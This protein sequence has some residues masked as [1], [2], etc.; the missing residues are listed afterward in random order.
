MDDIPL[1]SIHGSKSNQD[2]MLTPW[3]LGG[4]PADTRPREE[5]A[6]TVAAN[7]KSMLKEIPTGPAGMNEKRGRG[8]DVERKVAHHWREY[9]GCRLLPGQ[10][11]RGYAIE[12]LQQPEPEPDRQYAYLEGRRAEVSR[13][14][15]NRLATATRRSR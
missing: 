4:I 3:I 10:P 7:E 13:I 9:I 11:P 1:G 5:A 2:P 8:R 12:R 6:R 15:S 14:S